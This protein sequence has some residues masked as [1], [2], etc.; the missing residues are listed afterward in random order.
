[1]VP[2][3]PVLCPV[4]CG[5]VLPCGAVLWRP[6]VRFSLLVVLV[7]VLSLCVRC[8]VALRVVLLRAGLIGAVVGAPCCAVSLCVVVSPLAF[9]GV[10]VLL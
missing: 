8:C 5:P 2:R 10:V 6:A 9:C 7:R 1:M 4:F 3:S